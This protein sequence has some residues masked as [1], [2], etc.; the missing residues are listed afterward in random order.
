MWARQPTLLAGEVAFISLALVALF[1]AVKNGRQHLLLWVGA[2]VGGCCNDIFF[3]VLPFV[4]NFWHAQCLLM[5][6]P[7]LPVYILAVY[8]A[9]IY[10]PIASSWRLP[11]PPPARFVAAAFT[12]GLLYA[13]FDCTGA[14]FLWWTWHDTD[15]AIE[16]R[17]LG[18]PIG[19]TMFTIM[20]T[21]CFHFLLHHFA[22]KH[23]SITPQRFAASL[24]GIALLGTPCMMLAMSPCQLLQLRFDDTWQ[25]TK[26]PGRPDALAFLVELGL[27][28]AVAGYA[29]RR[30]YQSPAP[31]RARVLSTPSF[32]LPSRP[33]DTALLVGSVAYF[34]TL[35]AVMALGE[36]S[37]VI[38]EGVH[39]S[40]RRCHVDDVD[41][42][43]Y[44]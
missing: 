38:A 37:N 40:I 19:S 34:T 23:K 18:V 6:T 27:L 22:L 35:V 1:H 17:W 32:L 25:P 21:F 3:M 33:F 42:S 20:H 10:V 36:P 28:S 29:M 14:K 5:L 24:L 26:L 31:E 4:D 8:I 9:F 43:N 12:G 44:S 2:L 11:A 30:A 15:A 41:L 7:R 13:P 16:E 39:Q